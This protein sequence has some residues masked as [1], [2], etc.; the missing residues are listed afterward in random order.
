MQLIYRKAAEAA[1]GRKEVHSPHFQNPLRS[2]AAF[3]ALRLE[4]FYL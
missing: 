1:K 4:F 2:F 3:A